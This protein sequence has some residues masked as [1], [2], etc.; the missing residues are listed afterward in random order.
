M[1]KVLV[2]GATGA[3]GK[4]IVQLLKN[5]KKYQ[6][7]AMVRNEGQKAQFKTDGVDTVMGDLAH[8]VS[9]TTKGIDKVIFAAGSGGK[10]VVNV[11]Q[12]GAKRLIDASKKERINKFVML[13]S[14]GADAPQGPLKEYLQSKQNADQYLD[15]SGLTFSIVRPGTLT[16]NEGTGKIKLK[17]KL[18]EQGEIPRWDVARTL[19][20]SLED[21]VAKNQSFEIINGET[22]INEA[23]S[24]FQVI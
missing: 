23:V 10:D 19:V 15:I 1:E 16:N 5:S 8:N 11:D 6:P 7:V 18:S 21:T 22:M 2:A 13:S 4:K 14:M 24:N 9:N 12:E 17:H 3:T 20:N